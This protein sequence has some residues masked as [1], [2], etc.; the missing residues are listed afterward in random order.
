MDFTKEKTEQLKEFFTALDAEKLTFVA[1][2]IEKGV[3]TKEFQLEMAK[4]EF[5]KKLTE[6]EGSDLKNSY[7][8]SIKSENCEYIVVS[9]LTEESLKELKKDGI[10]TACVT[11]TDDQKYQAIIK[12]NPSKNLQALK[13]LKNCA[14][15]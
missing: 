13:N 1:T 15:F 12:T 6:K 8:S 14:H 4:E 7:I 3:E 5:S 11:Q 9:G 2:P 10:S